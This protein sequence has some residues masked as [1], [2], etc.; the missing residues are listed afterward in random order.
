MNCNHDGFDRVEGDGRLRGRGGGGLAG[1][2]GDEIRMRR[3]VEANEDT[4][5]FGAPTGGDGRQIELLGGG[6]E[7]E[8]VVVLSS[9]GGDDALYQF[10]DISSENSL[11]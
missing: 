1:A 6:E 5:V 3:E 10:N 7:G 9:R 2:C 4:V 8:G 11:P